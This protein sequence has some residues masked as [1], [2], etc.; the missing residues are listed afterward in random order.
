MLGLRLLD[1]A[2]AC[3]VNEHAVWTWEA[4]RHLPR[5]AAARQ[6]L[7]AVLGLPD[8]LLVSEMAEGAS[9]AA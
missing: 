8:E 9:D 6:R 7:A 1:V 2:E 3:G 5:S 4:G